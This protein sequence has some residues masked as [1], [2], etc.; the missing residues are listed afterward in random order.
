MKKKSFVVFGLGRF[1]SALARE[2]YENGYDVLVVDKNEAKVRQ[3]EEYATQHF[4]GSINT[5]SQLRHLGITDFDVAV[6][7]VGEDEKANIFLSMLLKQLGIH[8]VAKAVT[9]LH[10]S[11]LERIGVD[12]IVFPEKEMGIRVA[13]KLMHNTAIDFISLPGNLVVEKLILGEKFSGKSLEELDL[14]RKY[15]INVIMVFRD[16]EVLEGL[17]G[18]MSLNENDVL[19]AISTSAGF[20]KFETDNY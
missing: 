9:N 8:V 10:A 13:H 16:D 11:I 17:T 14:R 15:G 4:I 6:V 19:L 18:T 5:E 2:L 20:A 3:M 7:A 12:E 1:G